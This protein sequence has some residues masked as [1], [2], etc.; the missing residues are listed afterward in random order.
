MW[1]RINTLKKTNP[2]LLINFLNNKKMLTFFAMN[3]HKN[4]LVFFFFLSQIVFFDSFGQLNIYIKDTAGKPLSGAMAFIREDPSKVFIADKK[5]WVTIPIQKSEV[6]FTMPDYQSVSIDY[7]EL[8]EGYQVILYTSP[9]MIALQE[10]IV[11]P[12]KELTIDMLLGN[13]MKNFKQNYYGKNVNI[14]AS[15]KHEV[16]FQKE[17]KNDYDSKINGKFVLGVQNVSKKNIGYNT[18]I[19]IHKKSYTKLQPYPYTIPFYSPIFLCYQLNFADVRHLDFIKNTDKYI[20]EI[21]DEENNY[22]VKFTPKNLKPWAWSGFF[23]LSKENSWIKEINAGLAFNPRNTHKVLSSKNKSKDPSSTLYYKKLE[24]DMSFEKTSKYGVLFNQL[25]C[26]AEII[27][28]IK[29]RA[30]A[31]Y[32]FVNTT[33]EFQPA[34]REYPFDKNEVGQFMDYLFYQ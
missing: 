28:K 26:E 1:V 11:K 27:H 34:T 3:W 15:G 25:E 10:L 31:P 6:I 30:Y 23:I 18:L 21:F 14:I 4:I 32:I 16:R 22:L 19:N 12:Q 17:N 33:L 13:F 20:Y 7:S 2:H 5:G 8:R 24:V 29:N 9:K